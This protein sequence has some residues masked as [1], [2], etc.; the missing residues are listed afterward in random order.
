MC[1]VISSPFTQGRSQFGVAPVQSR[2]ACCEWGSRS[3]FGGMCAKAGG[4]D[5]VV[6]HGNTVV[7]PYDASKVDGEW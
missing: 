2:V 1:G 5:A 3:L 4:L 6:A 7:G